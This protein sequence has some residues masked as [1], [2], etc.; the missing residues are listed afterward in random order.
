MVSVQSAGIKEQGSGRRVLD[1]RCWMLDAGCWM[2]RKAR[3]FEKR[4][5]GK[6]NKDQ[7]SGNAFDLIIRSLAVV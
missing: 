6:R 5:D 7:G 2:L 3:F 1:A 4:N